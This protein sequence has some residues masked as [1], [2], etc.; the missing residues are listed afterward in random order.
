MGPSM[1]M[2]LRELRRQGLEATANLVF[3]VQLMKLIAYA[4]AIARGE[5]VKETQ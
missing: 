3:V 4:K 5:F 2:M 1:W